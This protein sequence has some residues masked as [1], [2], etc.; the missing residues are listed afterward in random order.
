[1]KVTLNFF[2]EPYRLYVNFW[3]W[4]V[5]RIKVYVDGIKDLQNKFYVVI[6]RIPPFEHVVW[7]GIVLN[8]ILM[9]NYISV[10]LRLQDVKHTLVQ[11]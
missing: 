1:M 2:T 8:K 9:L 5:H 6:P 11:T 3:F 10:V 4:N 7:F